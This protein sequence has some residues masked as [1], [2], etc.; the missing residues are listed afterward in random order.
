MFKLHI[1]SDLF[2]GFNEFANPEDEIL[3]NVDLVV[4]N[5]N[6][7]NVKRGMLYVET[8][9]HKYPDIPFVYNLGEWERYRDALLKYHTELYDNIKTR[10]ISNSSW[11]KN[12]HFGLDPIEL[13]LKN[14]DK[15]DILC[16]YGFPKIHSCNCPWEDTVWFKEYPLS[17]TYNP[18]YFI[19]PSADRVENC[20]RSQ[21]WATIDLINE[22]HER[23]EAIVKAWELNITSKKI[24]VTHLNPFNDSRYKDI[25][26]S[27]FEFHL[28]GGLWIA[29][30]TK[31]S[32]VQYLGARLES[33]PG[34]GSAARN[35]VIIVN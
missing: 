23:E 3:P 14:G 12:L 1:I 31:V 17:V 2:L 5:G 32:N 22:E 19:P 24:L 7:G 20:G 16:T 8:M 6:I 25:E 28:N 10:S 18:A 9:C 15:V 27:P 34:R 26:Y 11:P 33:N 13:T 35:N 4:V 29:A 30:D 21:V